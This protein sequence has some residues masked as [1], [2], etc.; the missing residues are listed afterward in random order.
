MFVS[1]APRTHPVAMLKQSTSTQVRV[2]H[3]EAPPL[4]RSH[5]ILECGRSFPA[6]A[7]SADRQQAYYI[8][9]VLRRKKENEI[10]GRKINDDVSNTWNVLTVC[11]SLILSVS[12]M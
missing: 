7:F 3:H 11:Q 8:G 5:I 1:R 4:T 9:K 2:N 6:P 10:K 12:E